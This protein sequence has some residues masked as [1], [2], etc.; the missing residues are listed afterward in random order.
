MYYELGAAVLLFLCFLFGFRYGLVLGHKASRGEIKPLKSPIK[1]IKDA[2]A[3]TEL[4]KRIEEEEERFV[5]QMD[6]DY[7]TALEDIRR[8]K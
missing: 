4:Q 5:S 7:E 1:A 6:Y 8:G 3:N 2:Q